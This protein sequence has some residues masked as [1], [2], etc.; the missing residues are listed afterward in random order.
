MILGFGTTETTFEHTFAADLYRVISE[1]KKGYEILDADA[2]VERH[3]V[4][5]DA[6]D[7]KPRGECKQRYATV[8]CLVKEHRYGF[9]IFL[10]FIHCN[11]DHPFSPDG[12]VIESSG[13]LLI[14]TRSGASY[15][16][17]ELVIASPDQVS[18]WLKYD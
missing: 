2:F 6:E 5:S 18:Q 16:R 11:R 3:N 12:A 1:A 8:Y 17:K 9:K 4:E 14:G 15:I 7:K 10:D 13:L